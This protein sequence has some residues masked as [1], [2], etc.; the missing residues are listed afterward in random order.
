MRVSCGESRGQTIAAASPRRDG[1]VLP[2]T[3]QRLSSTL[4]SRGPEL[5]SDMES[6]KRIC[7][8]P[9]SLIGGLAMEYVKFGRTGL[10]VSRLCLG[11]MTYG[12]PDRGAHPWTLA[13]EAS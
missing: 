8:S 1:C 10:E 6:G 3:S 9:H 7:C 4:S 2:E 5:T 13:E 11:C 12:A